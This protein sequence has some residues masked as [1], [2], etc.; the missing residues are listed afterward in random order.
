MGGIEPNYSKGKCSRPPMGI[1]KMLK[2]YLHWDTTLFGGNMDTILK[3]CEIVSGISAAMAIIISIIIYR[4]GLNRERKN[5]TL[6]SLSEI[7]KKYFNSKKLDD[8]EKLK[9]LNELEYFAT[10]VNEKVYDIKTV[11]IMSGSRL[12]KQYDEW[13]AVFIQVRKSRFGN[14][15]AYLE[16]EKMIKRLKRN[17]KRK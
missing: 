6:K 3:I 12:I 9:Y 10:G 8:E 15:R 16:Y 4:H 7:R 1:E 14:E 13:A 11:R 17:I 5:D 2:M